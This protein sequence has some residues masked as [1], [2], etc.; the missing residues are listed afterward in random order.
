MGFSRVVVLSRFVPVALLWPSMATEWPPHCGSPAGNARW[1]AAAS[2]L[3]DVLGFNNRT[4][5]WSERA[6]NTL[7]MT[8][9]KNPQPQPAPK[10]QPP[11]A[12]DTSGALDTEGGMD[13]SVGSAK[14]GDAK[15]QPDKT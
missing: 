14:V 10:P 1:G 6:P 5:V 9:D 15:V 13:A 4:H 2:G 7:P 12:D 8:D 11:L 3:T